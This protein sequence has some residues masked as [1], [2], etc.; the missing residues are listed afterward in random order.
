MAITQSSTTNEPTS[1]FDRKADAALDAIT[2]AFLATVRAQQNLPLVTCG[3]RC[4]TGDLWRSCVAIEVESRAALQT[5]NAIL[6]ETESAVGTMRL[7]VER[8]SIDPA[9]S[10]ITTIRIVGE[11]AHYGEVLLKADHVL[12]DASQR[13]RDSH[14]E[15]AKQIERLDL[16]IVR[17][18]ATC[19]E[20]IGFRP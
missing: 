12:I 4:S 10:H 17:V 3:G 13:L 1:V 6:R 20:L 7:A 19:G 5:A 11:L 2:A 8:A 18:L 9:D 16:P 15:T 14:P